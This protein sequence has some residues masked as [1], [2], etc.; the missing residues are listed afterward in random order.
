MAKTN[1]YYN[2]STE[3]TRIAKKF[4]GFDPGKSGRNLSEGDEPIEGIYEHYFNKWQD[5]AKF[6]LAYAL[7]NKLK[8]GDKDNDGI[9]FNIE[10][11]DDIGSSTSQKKQPIIKQLIETE[12]P[13]Y[14]G[15]PYKLA[16]QYIDSG[17]KELEKK[18]GEPG[19][20]QK[21][22]LYELLD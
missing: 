16:I 5:A 19:R 11:F 3:G 13:D 1:K 9:S 2:L 7:A 8:P 15:D 10:D 14:D 18:L 22:R 20:R 6:A 12:F 4:A 17:L 21:L